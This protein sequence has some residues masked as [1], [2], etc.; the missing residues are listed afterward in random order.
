MPRDED[1]E[2]LLGG[3][4]HQSVWSSSRNR[5]ASVSLVALVLAAAG[6]DGPPFVVVDVGRPATDPA[7]GRG[8]VEAVPGFAG[9]V[10]AAVFGQGEGQVEDQGPFGVFAG[11]DAFEHLDRDATLEQLVEHDQ[12]FEQV[13]AEPVDFL[14]GQHVALAQVLQPL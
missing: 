6:E 1:P 3:I 2:R 11:R 12:S 10:A 14:H 9:D 8:R 4:D 5:A 13:A 7:A